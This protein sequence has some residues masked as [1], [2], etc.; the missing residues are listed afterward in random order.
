MELLWSQISNFPGII[1]SIDDQ[2]VCVSFRQLSRL[3]R[4]SI[5]IPVLDILDTVCLLL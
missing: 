2:L 4:V 3:P 5:T 1:W